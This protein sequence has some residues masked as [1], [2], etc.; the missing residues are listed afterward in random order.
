MVSQLNVKIN[1]LYT[2]MTFMN[3]PILKCTQTEHLIDCTQKT[4]C[5][6]T[7]HLIN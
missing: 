4:D 5:R 7:E 1:W 6:M 3:R 2:C